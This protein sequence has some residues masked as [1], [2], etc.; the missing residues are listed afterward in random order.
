MATTNVRAFVKVRG[1]DCYR[2]R[3]EAEI[4]AIQRRKAK[5]RRKVV[6]LPRP[7]NDP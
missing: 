6:P 4:A 3:T 1:K 2:P 7:A 5:K